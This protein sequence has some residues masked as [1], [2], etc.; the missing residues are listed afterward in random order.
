MKQRTLK[1]TTQIS[2]IGVHSGKTVQLTLHPAPLDT[3]I[4][5]RRIDIH[6]AVNIPA[7]SKYVSDTR[8]N[9]CLAKDGAMVFTVEHVLSAFAGMGVDNAYVD[10]TAAEMPVMDGSAQPFVHLIRAAGIEQQEAPKK[11]LRIKRPI[12]INDGDKFVS[13]EPFEGFKFSLTVDFDHP[14]FRS[15]SQ[16]ASIDLA[17]TSFADEISYARTF[18]FLSDY[19]QL[20]KH[21]LGLGASLENTLVLDEQQV[22]NPEGLR[23]ADEFVRHKI[24]DAVGDLYLLGHNFIGAFTGYKSGHKLN[25]QLREA[26]LA[27]SSAWEIVSKELLATSFA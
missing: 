24:L 6:P 13:I 5:F 20:R 10:V 2:G 19:E 9:T 7:I 27:D 1:T 16:T 18:G 4:I 12:K 21:N 3:G 14:V 8:L 25:H 17:T 15:S 23:Y 11:F 22:L 26:V